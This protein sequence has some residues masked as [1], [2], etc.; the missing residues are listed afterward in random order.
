MAN[1]IRCADCRY[2]QVDEN[3]SESS[4]TAYECVNSR[5]EYHKALL[6]VTING[7]M[8]SFISW[9]GCEHGRVK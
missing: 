2:A 1:R 5:S 3:A 6:N 9:C 7:N 4:W 8:Q